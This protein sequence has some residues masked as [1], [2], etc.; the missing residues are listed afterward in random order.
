MTKAPGFALHH[1]PGRVWKKVHQL[2][3][4]LVE[5]WKYRDSMIPPK[6]MIF[7]GSGDF[8]QV[9][10]EFRNYLIDLAN[11]QP[12]DKV[13]DVGCGLGRMAVPLTGYLSAGGA[14]WGFDIVGKAVA[15]CTQHISSKFSNFHFQHSNV[16]NQHYNHRG[17]IEARDFRF[18]FA[19]AHFDFVLLTSVFTHMLPSDMENYLGEISRV[20]RPGGTCFITFFLLNAESRGLIDTG[21][22]TL[23][24]SH[25]IQGCV[26]VDEDDPEAAVAYGET[27]VLELFKERGLD[28]GY[29][30]RYG[31]WCGRESFLTYQDVI[32]ARKSGARI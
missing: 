30:I 13:L 21:R 6:S 27:R 32:I 3:V 15:W 18:P 11:L 17:A 22:S 7:I 20:L 5:R 26:V 25:E 19:D 24:L 1:L 8:E 28:V 14:Y 23:D 10:M 9:G 4:D 2:P 31:S 12:G 29:P 16:Y